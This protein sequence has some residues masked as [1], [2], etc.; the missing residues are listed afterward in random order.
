M[1]THATLAS[2]LYHIDVEEASRA[3]GLS[4]VNIVKKLNDGGLFHFW[5]IAAMSEA[6]A[7]KVD[8]DLKLGGRIGRDGWVNQARALLAA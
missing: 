1:R 8:A 7:A 3:S 6:D 5:Q 2:S 4:R